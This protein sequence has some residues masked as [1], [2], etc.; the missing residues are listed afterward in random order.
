MKNN[1]NLLGGLHN[2]QKLLLTLTKRGMSRQIAYSLV[3]KNAMN[4]WKQ[5]STFL[6]NIIKVILTVSSLMRCLYKKAS[7]NY[8]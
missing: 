4:A 5:N 2:S 3:Q 8:H 1:L 7:M 6:N